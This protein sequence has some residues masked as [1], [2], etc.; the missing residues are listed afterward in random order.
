MSDETDESAASEDS[1]NV[2]SEELCDDS[3]SG[4]DSEYR[5]SKKKKRGTSSGG[6]VPTAAGKQPRKGFGGKKKGRPE[7]D[8]KS[9]RAGVSKKQ[10][11]A[12][13]TSKESESDSDSDKPIRKTRGRQ[14]HYLLDEDFDSSDDGIRPGVFRPDTPPEER[15]AFIKKQEEIKRMLAEKNAEAAKSFPTSSIDEKLDPPPD[16]ISIIPAS[17]IESAKVLDSDY[18]KKPSQ[19]VFDD[20]PD[21]FNPDDMDDEELAKMMEEEDFAQHQLRLAGEHIKNKKLKEGESPSKKALIDASVLP[22][23]LV[24]LPS[25]VEKKLKKLK[26]D[27][28]TQGPTIPIIVA[29]TTED[30][31]VPISQIPPLIATNKPHIP[32]PHV[33]LQLPT[34]NLIPSSQ[35]HN[36]PQSLRHPML[37]HHGHPPHLYQGPPRFPPGLPPHLY[38]QMRPGMQAH[39]GMPGYVMQHSRGPMYPEM[40]GQMPPGMNPA[41]RA[42]INMPPNTSGPPG[43]SPLMAMSRM[44][45]GVSPVSQ[46]KPTI[47]EPPPNALPLNIVGARATPPVLKTALEAPVAPPQIEASPPKKRGRRKKITPLRDDLP[48]ND[49]TQ[50]IM[51]MKP[52]FAANKAAGEITF[53]YKLSKKKTDFNENHF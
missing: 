1:E 41:L 14:M 22:T 36:Q 26:D 20:L 17:I 49:P 21:D 53:Y 18:H 46:A 29:P 51:Q 15:E 39:P 47:L 37:S 11:L 3:D 34:G 7:S 43:M 30:I 19:S 28:V 4:S 31:K 44:P 33:R 13:K 24:K 16:N 12:K 2:D 50:S 48:K 23:K 45:A 25:K 5:W 27:S 8:D 52:E 42:L 6:V 40:R 35:A 10:L 38:T 9:F 32:S